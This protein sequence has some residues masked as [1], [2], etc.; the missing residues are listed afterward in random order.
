V[1]LGYS[2]GTVCHRVL[3]R[4]DKVKTLTDELAAA[5]QREAELRR[6]INDQNAQIERLEKERVPEPRGRPS[7]RD[8]YIL[9]PPGSHGE[10]GEMDDM[11]P[12]THPAG[13]DSLTR[14]RE[15]IKFTR[16]WAMPCARTFT[17]QPIKELLAR[18]EV[19]AGWL[20]PMAGDFSPAEFTND[21]HPE[22]RARWQMDV[23]EFAK[24]A[25][26][27]RP[28]GYDGCLFDPPYSPR[29][30]SE[31]Y[32]SHGRKATQEQTNIEVRERCAG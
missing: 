21:H 30:V 25:A 32:K 27:M 9:T 18:Y 6:T 5:K 19:G 8:G 23:L 16:V 29:Q 4:T 22:R 26:E 2:I 3:Q 20:H 11:C 31:H 15:R 24:L 10:F 1:V 14:E 28:E 12:H 13:F 17:I 7:D